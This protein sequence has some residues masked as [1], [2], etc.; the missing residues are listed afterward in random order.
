ML[1]NAVVLPQPMHYS[2]DDLCFIVRTARLCTL[3]HLHLF[4][5][6]QPLSCFDGQLLLQAVLQSGVGAPCVSQPCPVPLLS[7]GAC[8]GFVELAIKA[9]SQ[10]AEQLQPPAAA[11]GDV[12]PLAMGS[13][14]SGIALHSLRA[15]CTTLQKLLLL[16][17]FINHMGSLGSAPLT[18][19]DH[20][21]IAAD[22]ITPLAT[23]L[24]SAAAALW[25]C[26]APAAAPVPGLLA[27]LRSN[28]GDY[29]GAADKGAPSRSRSCRNLTGLILR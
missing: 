20:A 1:C 6:H 23:A 19:A 7:V 12:P 26:K 17:G 28:K 4:Y 22:L 5:G 18:A 2:S 16:L 15:T 9:A 21:A 29:C 14:V 8:S 10:A 11:A 13:L 25:L 24:R 3:R 27:G